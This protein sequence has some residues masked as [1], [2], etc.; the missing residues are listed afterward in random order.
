MKIKLCGFKEEGSTLAAIKAG[1][2]FIG[3]IFNENSPRNIDLNAAEKLAKI[4]PQ[5]VDRVA[6]VVDAEMVFLEQI[7][8]KIS[9]NY[10]QFHGNET[11]EFLEKFRQKFPQIKI[12]KAFKIAAKE[13]LRRVQDFE[14]IADLFLFDG[15]NPGAGLAFDWNILRDFNCAK[16]WF[17]AGG[18]NINNIKEALEKTGAPMVDISSG[19]EE[20]RG[21]KSPKLIK[22]LMEELKKIC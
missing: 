19:I 5:N 8:A 17:L 21:E 18:L 7:I 15:K 10:I 22:Q 13:D 2:N 4:I 14:N 6:V 16:S 20:I 3:F 9:P 12:I 1:A 11:I